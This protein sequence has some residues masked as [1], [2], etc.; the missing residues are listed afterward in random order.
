VQAQVSGFT[1]PTVLA[2]FR[3]H[4]AFE[5]AACLSFARPEAF[6]RFRKPWV[7]LARIERRNGFAICLRPVCVPALVSRFTAP[8]V[9]AGIRAHQAFEIAACFWFARPEAFCD[10]VNPGSTLRGSRGGTVFRFCLRP[11]WVIGGPRRA[12]HPVRRICMQV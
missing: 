9:L 1:A 5:I 4:Q 11:V 2:G 3:A 7:N 12:R 8:T 10:S 6:L